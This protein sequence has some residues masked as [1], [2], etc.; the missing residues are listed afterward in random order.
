VKLQILRSDDHHSSIF[1]PFSIHVALQLFASFRTQRLEASARSA[2][3]RA[4]GCGAA[5]GGAWRWALE[6]EALA[7]ITMGMIV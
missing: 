6:F 3:S 7:G 5:E 1:H 2:T 4:R